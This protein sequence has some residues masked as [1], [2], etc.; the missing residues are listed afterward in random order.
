MLSTG[1]ALMSETVR[2]LD[3][4][5]NPKLLGIEDLCPP[6]RRRLEIAHSPRP[7][8]LNRNESYA[9]QVSVF[10]S[11]FALETAF[12][13][14]AARR[15]LTS[16]MLTTTLSHKYPDQD[17]GALIGQAIPWIILGGIGLIA[18]ILLF[19]VAVFLR[20]LIHEEGHPLE[21]TSAKVV[22]GI[23]VV[24]L[25]KAPLVAVLLFFGLCLLY[26][27]FRQ[28][29]PFLWSCCLDLWLCFRYMLF[30]S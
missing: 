20:S 17:F 30:R 7:H 26:W 21:E 10:P 15:V 18:L 22:L 14:A 13:R 1:D 4:D 25:F 11:R 29:F 6:R 9:T 12:A 23:L 3:E 5:S 24:L 8:L 2:R 28:V 16:A 27:L 19:F